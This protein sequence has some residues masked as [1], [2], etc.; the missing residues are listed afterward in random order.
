MD[1]REFVGAIKEWAR[2]DTRLTRYRKW[3]HFVDRQ[4]RNRYYAKIICS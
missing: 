4:L 2:T 1:D 3:N